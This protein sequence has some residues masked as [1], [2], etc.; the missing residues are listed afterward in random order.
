MSDIAPVRGVVV[1]HGT[2]ADGLIDAVHRITGISDG[3]LEG[4]SNRG[5]SPEALL[6]ELRRRVSAGPTIIFTDMPSG[7]CNLAA[8]RL[9]HEEP[10]VVVIGGIN[11]PLLLDFV[12]HRELPLSELST[13]LVEKGRAAISSVRVDLP[14]HGNT[15]L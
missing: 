3:V 9:Q 6:N 5:L 15:P 1:G 4:V 12:L 2:I 13:R 10:G 8:R 7:S 14:H 11:L